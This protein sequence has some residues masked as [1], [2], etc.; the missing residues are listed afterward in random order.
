M[1]EVL[2]MDDEDDDEE[3]KIERLKPRK[4]VRRHIQSIFDEQGPYYQ[5]RA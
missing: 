4:R 3:D 2:G 1:P 5:R